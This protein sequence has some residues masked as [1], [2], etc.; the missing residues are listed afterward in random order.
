MWNIWVNGSGI[1]R[2]EKMRAE[3]RHHQE[4]RR[5]LE[6]VHEKRHLESLEDGFGAMENYGDP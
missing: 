6:C 4:D 2:K 3:K 1:R 5:I